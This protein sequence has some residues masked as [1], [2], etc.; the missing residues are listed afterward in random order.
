MLIHRLPFPV[1]VWSDGHCNATCRLIAA[2][3]FHSMIVSF[4]VNI[5]FGAA[6]IGC[7]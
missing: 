6:R 2:V 5:D 1:N 3:I 7:I 4:P